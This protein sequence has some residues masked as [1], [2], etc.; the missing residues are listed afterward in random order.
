MISIDDLVICYGDLVAVRGVSLEVPTGAVYGLVGPNGAGK[1][2]LIRALAGLL[3]P[4]RGRLSIRGI[5]VQGNPRAVRRFLGYMPD[6]FG[7]Y[8]HLTVHEYLESFGQ[9]YDLHPAWLT[10]RIRQVLEFT[11]LTGKVDAE[12]GGLSRGMKQRLCLARS[13]LHDPDV[14]LLDEPASG[15]DPRGRYE[16][17]QLIAQLGAARK[18]ILVS[19]HILPELADVCN[20]V[21]IMERG[22]LVACGP[23]ASI[24]G[25]AEP[26]RILNLR[27]LGGEV[28]RVRE[29]LHD[30]APLRQITE[31]G[32]EVELQVADRDEVVAE[33]VERLVAGGVRIGSLTEQRTDLEEAYLRLTHGE[34]A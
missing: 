18:T 12:V 3:V 21:A 10:D 8:D 28:E 14:L 5:D 27:P 17:R 19:S 22:N 30:F 24:S 11:D 6:F 32:N 20:S 16:L 29:V 4:E 34:L 26:V 25:Q 9:L 2:S 31:R 13:L 15:V 33:L 7:V 23:V 1:T